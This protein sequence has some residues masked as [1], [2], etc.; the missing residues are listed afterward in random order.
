MNTITFKRGRVSR[1]R[2]GGFTL[3]ELLVVIAIIAILAGMLLPALSK[4]KTK[5]QG[6][7]CMNNHRQL[8]IAWRMY[9]DDNRERLPYAYG[10]TTE[11]R[12]FA[13][14]TG[15]LDWN[16]ANYSN[17]DV[18]TNIQNSLLWPYCGKAAAIFRCPADFSTVKVTVGENKGRAMPRVRSMVM[19]NWVGGNGD[20][21]A[22]PW[23]YWGGGKYRVY[24][25]FNDMIDPG[26]AS[27]YVF[28][29]ER[30][31]SI[32]DGY[33]VVEMTG[34]P[35]ATKT[36]IVDYPGNYHNRAAGFSFAD[37][38]A[39]IRRWVDD[40]TVPETIKQL[41]IPSPNNKDIVWLWQRAT[42]PL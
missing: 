22:E 18:R 20:N 14:I 16:G 38:H 4:A 26:P 31:E 30:K 33:W 15:D 24:L 6:V 40:R 7:Q 12:K 34:Y 5:A 3:I 23:G 8:L 11:S 13:W 17:F 36:K 2:P 9:V 42:R 1:S 10:S 29:D 39:E 41:N 35:D 37:G 32:N 19:N 25:K 27:T 28:L 21:P